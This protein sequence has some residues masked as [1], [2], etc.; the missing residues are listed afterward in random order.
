MGF[1]K[2][3][4]NP[5]DKGILGNIFKNDRDPNDHGLIG[6]MFK[7]DRNPNDRGLVGN[8]VGGVFGRKRNQPTPTRTDDFT[9]PD[10]SGSVM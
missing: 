7:N 4:G 8:L 2:G 10:N 6:N 1:F 3:N 5:N 9:P